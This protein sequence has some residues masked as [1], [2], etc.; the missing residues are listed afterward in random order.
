MQMRVENYLW[1]VRRGNRKGHL[2]LLLRIE[3]KLCVVICTILSS[4]LADELFAL[5]TLAPKATCLTAT[6]AG[7]SIISPIKAI[8]TVSI[9]TAGPI[10]IRCSILCLVT[11]GFLWSVIITA[12]TS[13]VVIVPSTSRVTVPTIIPIPTSTAP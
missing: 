7:L 10:S 12:I 13:A 4:S 5:E 2:G 3:G 6:K 11:E 1:K 8:S 9:V